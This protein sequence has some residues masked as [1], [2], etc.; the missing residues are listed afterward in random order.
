M[1]NLPLVPVW[2]GGIRIAMAINFYIKIFLRQNVRSCKSG[3][4]L[5]LGLCDK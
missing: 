3:E 5:F 1:E 2:F 4:L